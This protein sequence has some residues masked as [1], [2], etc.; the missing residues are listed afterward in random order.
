MP[1]LGRALDDRKAVALLRAWI[2]QMK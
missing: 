2:A 1:E